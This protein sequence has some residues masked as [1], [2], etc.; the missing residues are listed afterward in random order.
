[1]AVSQAAAELGPD[2]EEL[3][4]SPAMLPPYPESCSSIACRCA[5]YCG[6]APVPT[7]IYPGGAVDATGAAGAFG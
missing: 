6:V 4:S 3:A 1:M 7:V 2:M 5:A